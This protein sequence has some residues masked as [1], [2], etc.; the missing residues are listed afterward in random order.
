MGGSSQHQE[1]QSISQHHHKQTAHSGVAYSTA[2]NNINSLLQPVHMNTHSHNFSQTFSHGVPGG[3]NAGQ[4]WSIASTLSS[5]NGDSTSGM[6]TGF[7]SSLDRQ[8]F[9]LQQ[10]QQQH[11][12]Q[13]QTS[14]VITS[15]GSS[16]N[17][18]NIHLVNHHLHNLHLNNTSLPGKQSHPHIARNGPFPPELATQVVHQHDRLNLQA[19]LAQNAN[20]FNNNLIKKARHLFPSGFDHVAPHYEKWPSSSIPINSVSVGGGVFGTGVVQTGAGASQGDHLNPNLTEL[21]AALIEQERAVLEQSAHRRLFPEEI[22]LHPHPHPPH[23]DPHALRHPLPQQLP[24]L[25][26]FPS[27]LPP[28]FP[29][30]AALLSPHSAL[31]P[32]ALDYYP[33]I[34]AFGRVAPTLLP[35]E[36]LYDINTYQ[37][38]GLHPLF[39]GFRPFRWA[40]NLSF[41]V[42]RFID[43]WNSNRL[44]FPQ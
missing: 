11:Q 36:V 8:I 14:P 2:D 43:R 38:L 12:H 10:Q 32:E 44:N 30:G 23:L 5:G 6:G 4:P 1:I 3:S 19:V 20:I 25:Q 29:S 18:S 37:L 7:S 42:L 31:T 21:Q 27:A 13:Q 9:G 40:F 39:A 35:P 15:S 33:A 28:G 34:D 24:F 17:L 41:V 16:P 22:L 26:P